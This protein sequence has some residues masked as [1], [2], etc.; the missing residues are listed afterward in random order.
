MRHP[1]VA[2]ALLLA[3]VA[4]AY[5]QSYEQQLRLCSEGT[6]PDQ[7]IQGC[8]AVIAAKRETSPAMAKIYFTRG[9]MYRRIGQNDAALS[10]Y[11]QSLRLNPTSEVYNSRCY[12][13]AITDRLQDA[14]KDCNQALRLNPKN[15]YAFDSRGFAN[16]KLGNLDAALADYNAALAIEPDRPYS[17]A[18]RGF[19][20]QRKGDRTGAAADFAA[21]R[22]QVPGILEEFG[23]YGVR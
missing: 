21:A 4:T 10:D 8:S 7:K 6:T 16:L 17:R 12:L 22:A 3:F 1:I 11:N 14:L 23:R 13:F 9:L 19:A 18:G 5:G 15:Q 20:R 2:G